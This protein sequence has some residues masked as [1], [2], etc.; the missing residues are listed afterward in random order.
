MSDD[1]R[2]HKDFKLLVL[3]LLLSVLHWVRHALSVFFALTSK[4]FALR[5]SL[6]ML[7]ALSSKLF[8]LSLSLV[9]VGCSSVPEQGQTPDYFGPNYGQITIYV[10]GP[11]RASLDITFDVL[12]VN[13]VARFEIPYFQILS[14]DGKVID[15]LPEFAKDTK[16]LLHLYKIMM[17]SG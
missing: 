3:G 4:L 2:F 15:E 1:K 5:S 7:H 10:N 14:E 11:D 9:F 17:L 16:R 6:S 13:I 12:T 8:A